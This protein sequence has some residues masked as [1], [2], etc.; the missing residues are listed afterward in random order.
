MVSAQEIPAL[1]PLPRLTNGPHTLGLMHSTPA[2]S[3]GSVSQPVGFQS[4]ENVCERPAS[5][6][7]AV[8]KVLQLSGVRLGFCCFFA[9]QRN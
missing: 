4:R 5:A 8:G 1:S 6:S 9:G 2:P 7:L 3:F